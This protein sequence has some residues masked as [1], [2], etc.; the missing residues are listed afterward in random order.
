MYCFTRCVT[1]TPLQSNPARRLSCAAI[2]ARRMSTY[3]SMRALRRTVGASSTPSRMERST[4]NHLHPR[5]PRPSRAAG[6]A[7]H[8]NTTN[9][10]LRA[11]HCLRHVARNQGTFIEAVSSIHRFA[12]C[13]IYSS[14]IFAFVLLLLLQTLLYVTI[15]CDALNCVYCWTYVYLSTPDRLFPCVQNKVHEDGG[16]KSHWSVSSAHAVHR[17]APRAS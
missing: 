9:R 6:S 16:V 13:V 2:F 10:P 5:T 14:L 3:V 4:S 8:M 7:S 15:H 1:G 17:R 12:C 11:R